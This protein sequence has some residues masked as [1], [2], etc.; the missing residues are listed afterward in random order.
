MG[1]SRIKPYSNFVTDP[2]L[3]IPNY[4][5]GAF[6]GTADVTYSTAVT[7]PDGTST[8]RQFIEGAVVGGSPRFSCVCSVPLTVIWGG[9]YVK[10]T[11][12]TRNCRIIVGDSAIANAMSVRFDLGAGTIIDNATT[13]AA[14]LLDSY[15][16]SVGSGWYKIGA[17]VNMGTNSNGVIVANLRFMSGTNNTY[18][19]DSTSALAFWQLTLRSGDEGPPPDMV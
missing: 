7:A 18:N 16:T 12:G 10:R 9:C 5:I 2:N 4:G 1:V 15:M 19:G 17:K 8:A 6:F 13:G 3:A 14:S 11:V